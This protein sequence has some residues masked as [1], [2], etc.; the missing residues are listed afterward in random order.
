MDV[1]R[2][3]LKHPSDPSCLQSSSPEG[4]RTRP[5][6]RTVFTQDASGAVWGVCV[7]NYFRNGKCLFG[8][9]IGSSSDLPRDKMGEIMPPNVGLWL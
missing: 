4:R 6:T 5:V 2:V 9:N 1:R 8:E 3:T 7:L